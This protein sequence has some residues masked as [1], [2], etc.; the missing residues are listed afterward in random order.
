MELSLRIFLFCC[1]LIYFSIIAVM[2]GRR[3]LS[4]RYTL[5]W[6]ICGIGLIV[7]AIFPTIVFKA[8]AIIGISNPVNAI[9]FLFF[10]FVMIMLLSLT[11]IVS[12]LND[13]AL[14][15]TQA[16]ALLEQRVNELEKQLSENSSKY[17]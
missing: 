8:S 16:S 10:V 9:F 7:F 14:R 1:I 13:K 4:L 17:S 12:G 5:V 11:S 15:L 6:I 3:S 2:L